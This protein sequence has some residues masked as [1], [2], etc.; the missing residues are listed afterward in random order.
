MLARSRIHSGNASAA[1]QAVLSLKEQ[2]ERLGLT[3]FL[4]N[5]DALLCRIALLTDDTMFVRS[6]YREKAP[7]NV[8]RTDTLKRYQY[9]TQAMAELSL[10]D[11]EA[12][13]LT[14]APLEPF[15]EICGRHIDRIHLKILSAAAKMRLKNKGWK[16]DLC[17]AVEIVQNYH[18]VRTISEYGVLV[19]PMLEALNYAG[20]KAFL[21]GVIQA[22]RTMAVF[23]PNFLQQASGIAQKLTDAEMQVLRLLCADKSNAE[24]GEILDIKL[25][26]VKSHISHILS[27]MGVSRRSEAKTA[28]RLC[29]IKRQTH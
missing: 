25:A 22:S 8:I 16:T 29:G 5:I 10:G 23:Y 17:C 2:F 28:A 15:F 1:K 26:T 21:E 14:L 6:W 3:R 24:I 20:D 12:A 4:S 18:F 19:L 27:K 13:L 7:K 11:N 9:I